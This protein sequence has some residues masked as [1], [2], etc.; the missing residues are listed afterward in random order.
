MEANS[1][2]GGLGKRSFSACFSPYMLKL[3]L[4]TLLTLL[5]KLLALLTGAGGGGGGGGGG[6]ALDMFNLAMAEPGVG[7]N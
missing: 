3:T 1:S 4:L 7:L 5:L 6:K 2:R